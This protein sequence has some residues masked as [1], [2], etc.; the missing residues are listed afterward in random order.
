MKPTLFKTTVIIVT[1]NR[2]NLLIECLES[3]LNQTYLVEKIILI[4]NASTDGTSNLLQEKGYL[5]NQKIEYIRLSENLGCS[6]GLDYGIKQAYD[7]DYDWLWIMDDDTI[8]TSAALEKLLDVISNSRNLPSPILLASKVLWIDNSLHKMNQPRFFVDRVAEFLQAATK[9]LIL[10]RSSSFVSLLIHRSAVEKYGLPQKHYFLWNDDSEYTARILKQETGYLVPESIVH[11]KTASNENV[12][13]SQKVERYYY[14]IRNTL[15]M[16][17]SSSWET[18]EKIKLFIA[19]LR[20]TK[21]YL[22]MNQYKLLA[23]KV[24]IHGLIDGLLFE[25]RIKNIS[26]QKINSI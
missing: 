11:H 3:V 10:I 25:N 22:K 18:H 16:L 8:P 14:H 21:N 2:K 6:G 19:L 15:F 9:G 26:E 17:R 1:F 13:C 4:D 24:N 23:F 12:V 20:D 5:I 7:L